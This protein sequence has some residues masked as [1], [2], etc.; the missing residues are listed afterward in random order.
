MRAG[1]LDQR[2]TIQTPATGQDAYGSPLTGW[3]DF[4][5]VWAGIQDLSGREYLA[6]AATQNATTSKITIRHLAGI[7]PSMR[8]L[9]GA[10]AF[11]IEAVLGQDKRQLLLMCSRGV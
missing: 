6:A 9:H 7:V 10:V 11:N 2:I 3:T 4:A 8:V 1:N 5:T